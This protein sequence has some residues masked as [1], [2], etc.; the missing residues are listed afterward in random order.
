MWDV[1][2]FLYLRNVLFLGLYMI[3]KKAVLFLILFIPFC[4]LSAQH[5]FESSLIQRQQDKLNK[6]YTELMHE[7]SSVKIVNTDSV[8][9]LTPWKNRNGE[10]TFVFEV[11]DSGNLINTFITEFWWYSS[12]GGEVSVKDFIVFVDDNRQG[13]TL[14]QVLSSGVSITS[15]EIISYLFD[16]VNRNRK[17]IVQKPRERNL[18]FQRVKF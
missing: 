5:S 8:P 7:V 4:F 18:K 13:F 12:L 17:F 16:Y 9:L 2:L 6:L 11:S 1:E 3:L 10:A 15:K 14:D